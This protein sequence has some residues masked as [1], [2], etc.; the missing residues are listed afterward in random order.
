MKYAISYLSTLVLWIPLVLYGQEHAG[1]PTA[2]YVDV[3]PSVVMAKHDYGSNMTCIRT[4]E[5]L[6]FVDCGMSTELATKFRTDMEA[7]FKKKTLGLIL[8]HAHTDHF[9]GMGAFSDVNTIA[10]ALGKQS[11]EKQLAIEFNE[12]TV[13]AYTKIFP[14]FAEIIETAKPEMPKVWFEDKK[15]IGKGENRLVITNTGGHTMDS[16]SVYYPREKILVAGDLVQVD[17]YP[18]FGDVTTDMKAWIKTFRKWEAKPIRKVCP[19]HGSVT[20]KKFIRTMR[21]YFSRLKVALKKMKKTE[22]P[23]KE[24]VRHKDLPEGYWPKDKDRPS[25]FDYCIAALYKSL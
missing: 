10:A 5:G 24:V 25:W 2:E 22:T 12:E 7:K 17:Q 14:K 21:T 6:Y 11:W 8:T 16:A 9:M 3:S 13:M 15:I 19:G 23:V 20:D 1:A 18:Y 4:D